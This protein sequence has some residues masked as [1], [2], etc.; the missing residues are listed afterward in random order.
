MPYQDSRMA[1]P[2][3][4]SPLI[5]NFEQQDQVFAQAFSILQEAI[6][7]QAFPAASRSSIRTA[8]D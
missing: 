4:S 8:E 5:E 7:H 3:T 2:E 6:T 1:S